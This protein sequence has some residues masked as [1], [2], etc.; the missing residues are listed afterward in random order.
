MT[1]S[2]P[3]MERHKDQHMIMVRSMFGTIRLASRRRVHPTH[4]IHKSLAAQ[5]PPTRAGG[6]VDGT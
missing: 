4:Q 5:P 3:T 1:Y 6:D 2:T